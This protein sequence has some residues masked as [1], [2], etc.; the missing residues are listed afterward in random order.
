MHLGKFLSH[1]GPHDRHLENGD[2]ST[3]L[4]ELLQGLKRS[5]MKVPGP[6][7]NTYR[8]VGPPLSSPASQVPPPPHTQAA[9]KVCSL[10][11]AYY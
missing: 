10:V 1:S 9:L 5:G 2:N 11:F 4:T 8:D 7:L 3:D 6:A